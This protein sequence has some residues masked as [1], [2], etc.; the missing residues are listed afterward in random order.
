L[1]PFMVK[2]F[3]QNNFIVSDSEA[4]EPNR[5][6][7]IIELIVMVERVLAIDN[8][9]DIDADNDGMSDFCEETYGIDDPLEDLDLDGLINSDECY[10][11]LDPTDK[12]TDQ[13]GELDGAEVAIGTNALNPADDPI[14]SDG[15]GLTNAAEIMVHFT[16][17]FNPDTDGG[18]VY[19][20]EE[21]SNLTE[22][23]STPDDDGGVG[24]YDNGDDGIYLVPSECDTCPCISTF[25]HK[26][27]VVEGDIFFPVILIK[28]LEYYAEN[29][30]EKVHIF[31]KG[32]EV[33]VENVKK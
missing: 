29:P 18:G 7:N 14:D 20:G 3:I 22:P 33:Q 30:K 31:S 11:G 27:D 17:P 19:D 32:N 28:Y 24:E 13:G 4:T 16:D 6:L 8:C 2:E 25:L 15:D 9:H 1:S 21:V 26:A 12:D 23:M 5:Q 10:Y